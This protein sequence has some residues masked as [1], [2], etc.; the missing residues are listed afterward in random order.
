MATSYEWER[1]GSEIMDTS[2]LIAVKE[3]I[4]DALAMLDGTG[5]LDG[6]RDESGL[7]AFGSSSGS[8]DDDEIE[9]RAI[10][11][12]IEEIENAG[13]PDWQY[14][15]M[16]IREDYFEDYAREPAE[17]IGAIDPNAL[18]PLSY[19]DWEAAAEALLVDY[20]EVEY[21]GTTYYARA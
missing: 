18:W 9:A 1:L 13:L 5:T 10:L 21:R 3:E 8:P 6:E 14:G 7:E 17:D 20:I 12:A 11:A 2:D 4:E 15:E 19:I 16:L